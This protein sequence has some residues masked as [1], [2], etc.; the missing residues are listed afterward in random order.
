MSITESKRLPLL[1]IISNKK[2]E[3]PQLPNDAERRL[4]RG[5]SELEKRM[6]SPPVFRLFV[7]GERNSGQIRDLLRA[8]TSMF[9]GTN[10]LKNLR[11]LIRKP[12]ELE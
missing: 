1:H 8:L 6:P 11:K 12:I 10:V 4:V 2:R 7:F 9:P 3:T 5:F